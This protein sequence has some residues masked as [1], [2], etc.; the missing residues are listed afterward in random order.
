MDLDCV[1]LEVADGFF[2]AV[3]F[4]VALD[5]VVLEV[6]D[7]V[8]MAVVLFV[9]VLGCGSLAVVLFMAVL[10]CGGGVCRPRSSQI[11]TM[12]HFPPRGPAWDLPLTTYMRRNY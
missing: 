2:M 12:R 10:G 7:G 9:A 5:R 11:A 1:F 4:F 3:V 6:A 8:F